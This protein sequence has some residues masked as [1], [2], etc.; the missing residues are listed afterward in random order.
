MGFVPLPF[1]VLV[2]VAFFV[3][4]FLDFHVQY[5]HVLNVCVSVYLSV[6]LCVCVCV[7]VCVWWE[8]CMQA[9]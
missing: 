5:V 1:P 2:G 3:M 4:N 9:L 8:C 6:R 7:C